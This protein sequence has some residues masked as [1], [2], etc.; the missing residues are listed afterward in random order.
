MTSG[1]FCETLNIRL[2]LESG[3]KDVERMK[4][5]LIGTYW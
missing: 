4:E 2:C 1:G 5:D 3:R